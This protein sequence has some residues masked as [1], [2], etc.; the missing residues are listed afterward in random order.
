MTT[1]REAQTA[2]LR[3]VY[4]S[5]VGAGP[6]AE[7]EGPVWYLFRQDHVLVRDEYLTEVRQLL[8]EAGFL[9]R[10][11]E[12]STGG[13]ERRPGEQVVQGVRL[14]RLAPGRGGTLAALDVIRDG[15]RVNGRRLE[16]LGSGVAA[17]DHLISI[18]SNGTPT[19]TSGACP[20]REPLLVAQGSPT[21][22]PP[23]ADRLAG[24]GVRVAVVDTGIDQ[25]SVVK[26]PWLAG[27]WGDPD[28]DIQAGNPRQLRPYAGH[29]TFIAG[30]IRTLAPAAEVVVRRGFDKA[31]AV[32]ESTLVRTLDR[33]LDRDYPDVIN[34]SAGT[35][36][37]DP[38]GLLSFGAF[39]R[40]RLRHHKGVVLVAA[41]GNQG[42]RKPFWPAAASWTVSVGALNRTWRTQADFTNYGGWVD[43]YAPGDDLVNAFPSGRY[44][45]VEPPKVNQQADFVDVASWSG[46]SFSTP[47]VCGLIAARMSRTGEN[48]R[49]A[50]A[51]LLMQARTAHLPGVGAVLLP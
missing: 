1:A 4:G 49:T 5:S 9:P 31:G 18:C 36:T 26:R 7:K 12:S 22:P 40:N 3:Q 25:E 34:L 48:G 37:W 11:D 46:T 38:T 42:D 16:G 43:A 32:F 24:E 30:V 15:T 10:A 41:A 8:R 21:L 51:A 19:G 33:V 20:A 39:Y 45:Y 35:F 28:A 6:P 27:V 44:K 2:M 50:A 23:T 29:G 47:V 13:E 17:P 14:L